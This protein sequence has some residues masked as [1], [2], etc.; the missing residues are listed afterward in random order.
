MSPFVRAVDA[1]AAASLLVPASSDIRAA[2]LDPLQMTP[3]Q[4]R[5]LYGQACARCRGTDGLRA[6]GMARTVSGPELLGR[7][8]WPVQVCRH[9]ESTGGAQ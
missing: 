1:S 6:G 7:L 5:R 9:H 8:A 3:E 4:T 2:V